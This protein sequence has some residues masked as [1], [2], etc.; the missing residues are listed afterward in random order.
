[1]LAPVLKEPNLPFQ[2]LNPHLR[3]HPLFLL[4]QS[5]HPSALP[6]S[7]RSRPLVRSFLEHYLL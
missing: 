2:D 4:M 6:V 1:M 5:T 3:D 7:I